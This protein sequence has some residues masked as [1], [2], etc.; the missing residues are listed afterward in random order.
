M[1]ALLLATER[2]NEVD[3]NGTCVRSCAGCRT[4]VVRDCIAFVAQD[5]ARPCGSTNPHAAGFNARRSVLKIPET[6]VRAGKRNN[7]ESNK[8]SCFST[9]CVVTR[10]DNGRVRNSPCRRE[11]EPTSSLGK[12]SEAVFK[13]SHSAPPKRL[14][15]NEERYCLY[16]PPDNFKE[17]RHTNGGF[18]R[19]PNGHFIPLL[20]TAAKC[21]PPST[22]LKRESVLIGIVSEYPDRVPSVIRLVLTVNSNHAIA[23]RY[24]IN[25]FAFSRRSK[26]YVSRRIDCRAPSSAC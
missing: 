24:V 11:C 15:D 25:R 26:A 3:P 17:T 9:P 7:E 8:R 1:R 19:V 4:Q 5:K 16:P 6:D 12:V 13:R 2:R 22:P 21:T 23:R 14:R 20:H 18:A 10:V